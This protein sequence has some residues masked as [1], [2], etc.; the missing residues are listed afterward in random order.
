MSIE[1]LLERIAVA[2][3]KPAQP[4][5]VVEKTQAPVEPSAKEP[6]PEVEHAIT[7]DEVRAAVLQLG[8]G[9]REHEA[10]ALMEEFGVKKIQ[11][12]KPEQYEEVVNKF[13]AVFHS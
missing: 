12:F 1:S 2:L 6:E 3:E 11:E 10:R 7:F 5:P 8:I 13:N 9:D 4:V